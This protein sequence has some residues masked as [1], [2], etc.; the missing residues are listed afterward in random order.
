M[1]GC[2]LCLKEDVM[3]SAPALPDGEQVWICHECET[4]AM[5]SLAILYFDEL[6]DRF[7]KYMGDRQEDFIRWAKKRNRFHNELLGY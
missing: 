5:Q 2:E 6:P 1:P 7:L 4:V 3:V